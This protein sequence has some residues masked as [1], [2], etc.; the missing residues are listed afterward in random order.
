MPD[1]PSDPLMVA[2]TRLERTTYGDHYDR[3][4]TP[5]LVYDVSVIKRYVQEERPSE[6]D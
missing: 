3:E 2:I 6:R 5:G 4:N 1:N